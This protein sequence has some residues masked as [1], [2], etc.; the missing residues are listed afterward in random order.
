MGGGVMQQALG[1]VLVEKNLDQAYL[2]SIDTGK[3]VNVKVPKKVSVAGMRGHK[4]YAVQ[5]KLTKT[6]DLT[7]FTLSVTKDKESP[8]MHIIVKTSQ[9][10]NPIIYSL[11]L[12]DLLR[13]KRFAK[14]SKQSG[15]TK[16]M[17]WFFDEISENVAI[18]YHQQ[19]H[20][21]LNSN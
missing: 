10:K 5:N 14:E 15:A 21:F 12:Q 17:Q 2:R 9:R 6:Y 16:A 11:T 8:V 3:V 19:I 7:Q 18:R 4:V 13:D 1:G 20:N